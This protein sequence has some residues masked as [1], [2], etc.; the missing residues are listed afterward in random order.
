[1]NHLD[2]KVSKTTWTEEEDKNLIKICQRYSSGLLP[3]LSGVYIFHCIAVF[4]YYCV[5]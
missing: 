3:S 2:E 4:L 1:M 5:N